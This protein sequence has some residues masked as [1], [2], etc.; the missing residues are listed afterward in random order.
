MNQ[1][2]IITIAL[3]II[4]A[5]SVCAITYYSFN[6]QFLTKQVSL[7]RTEIIGDSENFLVTTV[8]DYVNSYGRRSDWISNS[9]VLFST[10]LNKTDEKCLSYGLVAWD[11]NQNK[12]RTLFETEEST[13]PPCFEK[14][15]IVFTTRKQEYVL[16]NLNSTDIQITVRDKK[17]LS[18]EEEKA[19]IHSDFRCSTAAMPNRPEQLNGHGLQALRVGDG[20]I[21]YGNHSETQIKLLNDDF[22]LLKNLSITKK[23]ISLPKLSYVPFKNSYFIYSMIS[24]SPEELALWR[25]GTPN[26]AWFIKKNGDIEKISVPSGPWA[27]GSGDKQIFPVAGGLVVTS[28]GFDLDKN[29]HLDPLKPGSAGAYFLENNGT[30]T[31]ILTGIVSQISVSPDGCNISFNFS[32]NWSINEKEKNGFIDLCNKK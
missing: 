26:F 24:L 14:E 6:K 4:A 28:K 3:V 27:E 20:I 23:D 13:Y 12:I 1:K 9:N 10:C 15:N 18:N 25:Q 2:K 21:D 29:G 19:K 31:K 7:E 30:A 8:P 11:T 5:L 17:N 22:S 32:K 16:S